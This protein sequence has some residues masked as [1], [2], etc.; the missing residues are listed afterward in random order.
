MMWLL[1]AILSM[2]AYAAT[3]ILG[4]RKVDSGG[5]FTP[6]ELFAGCL[7]LS[8]VGSLVLYACGLGESGA[9]PWTLLVHEPLVVVSVLCCTLYWVLCLISYRSLGLSVEAALGGSD[10]IVFFL[11]TLL[12]HFLFGRLGAAREMLHPARL[13]PIVIALTGAFLLPRLEK[14]EKVRRRTVVGMLIL[15]LALV[16]D[17]GNTLITAII[18]DEQR[19]GPVDCLI[20]SWLA[21]LPFCVAL[22]VGLRFARGRWFVPFRRD[23]QALVYAVLV[24]LAIVTYLIASSY[25]AVRAGLAFVAA[26]VFTL[27]GARIFL[28]EHYPLR[29]NLCIW[30]IILAAIA[31]CLADALIVDH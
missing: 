31:F 5:M 8:F 15:F 20:S 6:V 26:P 12:L 24:C 18:L 19:M 14:V 10:A 7:A 23:G 21:A 27:I 17:G 11:G 9:A 2:L 4:K 25:D 22:L 28:K 3:D 29:Q 30:T 13:I 16:F 1:F